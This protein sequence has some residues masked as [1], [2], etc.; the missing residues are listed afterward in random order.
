MVKMK[1]GVRPR[2]FSLFPAVLFLACSISACSGPKVDSFSEDLTGEISQDI[3]EEL[4]VEPCLEGLVR[5]SDGTCAPAVDECETW[6]LPLLGGGCIPIGPRT[7]PTTWAGK[8]VDTD[9]CEPGTVEECKA[10]FELTPDEVSCIPE[11]MTCLTGKFEVPGACIAAGP[12]SNVT[13]KNAYWLRCPDGKLPTSNGQCYIV[14]SRGCPTVWDDESDEFCSKHTPLECSDGWVTSEDGLYCLPVYDYCEKGERPI[15][16]GGCKKV[17]AST[18]CPDGPFAEVPEGS[19]DVL[20]VANDSTCI[21]ECGTLE[22]PFPTVQEALDIAP[23]HAVVMV[24]SGTYDVGLEIRKPVHII[25]ACAEKTGFTGTVAIEEADAPGY[26]SANVLVAN[27]GGVM[28]K[29]MSF[30][31][32]AP[33]LVAVLSPDVTVLDC[34]FDKNMGMGVFTA[35]S[36]VYLTKSW[37]A[38]TEPGPTEILYGGGVHAGSE[39]ELSIIESVIEDV[40]KC[41]ASVTGSNTFL[42]IS[43]S[44]IRN[45][46][47]DANGIGSGVQ[48]AGQSKCTLSVTHSVIEH[49]T[50]SGILRNGPGSCEISETIVRDTYQAPEGDT[51]AGIYIK[52]PGPVKIDKTTVQD[53]EGHGIFCYAPGTAMTVDHCTLIDNTMAGDDPENYSVGLVAY[54]GCEAV[55]TGTTISGTH[56]IGLLAHGKKTTMDASGVV[57][58]GAGSGPAS[59]E[60]SGSTAWGGATMTLNRSVIEQ[61]VRRGVEAVNS[62]TNVFVVDSVVRRT[63]AGDQNAFGINA[64][65]K[66]TVSITGSVVEDSATIGLT[67]F[68]SSTKMTITDSLVRGP[69]EGST[70]SGGRG[71]QVLGGGLLELLRTRIEDSR[72]LGVSVESDGSMANISSSVIRTTRPEYT[73]STAIGLQVFGMGRANLDN[74][75]VEESTG[76]GIAVTDAGSTVALA[77]VQCSQT[78]AI[79]GENPSGAGIQVSD[80]ATLSM[81]DSLIKDAD[82]VGLL[83]GGAG[84]NALVAGSLIKDINSAVGYY[85]GIGILAVKG[86]QVR[87]ETSTI[88]DVDESGLGAG[89]AG[90]AVEIYRSTIQKVGRGAASERGRGLEVQEGASVSV[91]G[92]HFYDMRDAH[93]STV[94]EGSTL[95][96]AGSVLGKTTG[97]EDGAHGEAVQVAFGAQA[98]LYRSLVTDV[99]T[100]GIT[101]SGL[102]TNASTGVDT[103]LTL[104]QCVLRNVGPG[105]TWLT[106]ENDEPVE[107]QVF[108]DGL[109]VTGSAKAEVT[110][111]TITG[112]G[113]CGVFFADSTGSLSNCL[114]QGNA[115]YGLA[116]SNSESSVTFDP[117]GSHLFGNATELPPELATEITN[118][119]GGLPVPPPPTVPSLE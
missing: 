2:H 7:C 20:F 94:H 112:N 67:V 79:P 16:G 115:S 113:R 95:S 88:T 75:L 38:E 60:A 87:L 83:V 24:A 111:T 47:P 103:F 76:V 64:D 68:N 107:F 109:M 3:L 117:N 45:I 1:T 89:E 40:H 108:G 6:E 8:K 28:L 54:E 58:H 84:S 18:E 85:L 33:G 91:I 70:T 101:V 17:L 69:A 110:S 118:N 44:V 98:N 34:K 41:G 86:A 29:G 52:A 36:H 10:G 65:Y 51:P 15:L 53:T 61:S 50:G 27:T 104:D 114:V 30:Q 42:S 93:I 39:G 99:R 37:I 119:P 102:E 100:S 22:A 62:G 25:G 56:S 11:E 12:Y 23:D 35:F 116:M 4:K 96:L 90:T 82:L 21:E 14:G 48:I 9:S 71:A 72:T 32:T 97:H 105:G 66:A 77:R 63:T 81:T 46:I 5:W 78:S 106:D 92:S 19:I 26:S 49:T 31:A 43:N 13:G 80:G 74:T 59:I 55:V 73:G 57:V